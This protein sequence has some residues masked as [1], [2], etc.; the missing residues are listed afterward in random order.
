MDELS[1]E[2]HGDA[3][4][5]QVEKHQRRTIILDGVLRWLEM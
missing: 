3:G 4:F 2:D 1:G 5:E